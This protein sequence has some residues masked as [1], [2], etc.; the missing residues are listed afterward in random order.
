[1]S[2]EL[3]SQRLR[4][5]GLTIE[6]VGGGGFGRGSLNLPG[7]TLRTQGE[8]IRLRTVGRKYTADQFADIT[9]HGKSPG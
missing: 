4:E 8:H 3:S 5:Y 7:G 9:V 1:M 2:I 6:Q